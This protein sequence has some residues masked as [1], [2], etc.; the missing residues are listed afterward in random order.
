MQSV[1]YPR[2]P[3]SF[4]RATMS[5]NPKIRRVIY[6][7]T[8]IAWLVF[9]NSSPA[10]ES[11][12]LSR[13]L[14]QG[15]APGALIIKLDESS[16]GKAAPGPGRLQRL[17]RT[18][19][20]TAIHELF[21]GKTLISKAGKIVPERSLQGI[22]VLRLDPNADVEQAA[23]AY[24]AE[25]SV[26][27]AQPNYL[28]RTT[29]TPSVVRGTIS[30]SPPS[31][32][33]TTLGT[34][35][36]PRYKDQWALQKL[37]WDR[38]RE[39]AR[40]F[41]EVLVAIV[42]SGIDYNHEDLAERIWINR[43]ELD[44][45]EGVD[46]DQNGYV[47]DVRGWDFT[48]APTLP[49]IGDYI[50]RDNDPMD[51]SGHG[52][53]VAGIVGAAS[54]N[55]I[56]I[57]G[58]APNAR[59]MCLRAGLR[60][61]MGG[62]LEDDDAASAIVY[63]ADNGA[64]VIN[65]S[66]GDPRSSPLI[67]DVIR[68]AAHK[69]CVLV[70]AAGNEGNEALYYPAGLDETIAVSA[71]ESG[72]NIASY[73]NYGW[74]LD[75]V[76]PGS[77]ILSTN[78][79]SEY[80]VLSG[81]SMAAPHVSALAALILGENPDYSADEVRNLILHTAEDLGPPG[82]DP[83]FG[84][85]RINLQQAL[86]ANLGPT[87]QILHPQSGDGGDSALTVVGTAAGGDIARWELSYGPGVHPEAWTLLADSTAP[88]W[89]DTLTLWKPSDLP[90]SLYVL[91]LQAFGYDGVPTE[92]R[93]VVTIDHTPPH[94]Q[95][96]RIAERIDG[97]RWAS[98][99]E[100]ATDDVTTGTI[101]FRPSGSDQA[102]RSLE[103]TAEG[104]RGRGAEGLSSAPL[105]PCSL[106]VPF[107]SRHS[108]EISQVLSP[109]TYDF[110]IAA[111]N[112]AGL[113][114]QGPDSTCTIRGDVIPEQSYRKVAELPDGY[115]APQLSDFDGDGRKEIILMPY[116]DG[117]YQ[118]VQLFERASDNTFE[119]VF[120]LPEALLPWNGSDADRDGKWELMGVR[121][122]HLYLF[123]SPDTHSFPS[124]PIWDADDVWGGEATDLDGDGRTEIIARS[125]RVKALVVF[126]NDG[127]NSFPKV[128]PLLLNPTEG[129]ND[130]GTRFAIG[131][132]DR[133]GH[134]EIIFGDSD[135][136]LFA[137]EAKANN[138]YRSTII[139]H[140]NHEREDNEP[141]LS[142]AEGV[143]ARYVAGGSDLDGDGKLEFIVGK[144]VGDPLNPR[145]QRWILSIYQAKG[146]DAYEI[147]WQTEIL[148][149]TS[150]GNGIAVGDADGDGVDEFVVCARPDI[151]LF[152]S[153]G[154]NAYRPLWHAE[155]GLT[156]VPLIGDA[157]SDGLP[158]IAFNQGERVVIYEMVPPSPALPAP[159]G[160]TAVP[161]DAST[162]QLTWNRDVPD[163]RTYRLYR[164][165][166]PDT[167]ETI[168]QGALSPPYID[169]PLQTDVTY[170]YALSVVD[171]DLVPPEGARSPVVQATPNPPP[172]LLEARP[173]LSEAE[174]SVSLRHV[175]LLFS[176][177]LG[178]SAQVTAHYTITPVLSLP[179]S[180]AKGEAEGA[181]TSGTRENPSANAS[182]ISFPLHPSSA[183][184][185]Y[186]GQRVVLGFEQAL[187]PDTYTIWVEGVRDTTGVFLSSKANRATFSV[188]TAAM[189][190]R[191]ISV[192]ALSS[193][194]IRLVFSE[195]IRHEGLEWSNFSIL[196][197]V[198]IRAIVH[199]PESREVR[200]LLTESD[201][202]KARGQ[203][204]EIRVASL[205]DLNGA[206]VADVAYLKW[207]RDDLSHLIVFP[208]PCDLSES[209]LTFA[210]L[211]PEA[212]I[213]IYTLDGILV[214][215][216]I[217]QDGDDRTEWDGRNEQGE[218]IGSGIYLYSVEGRKQRR[219]GKFAV[220]R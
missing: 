154:E 179:L 133:D 155:T 187:P 181:D 41:D 190:T 85:G 180:E 147:E 138:I 15:Y 152:K 45:I 158:E 117:P 177:P 178:P 217:E 25:P 123:E 22:Y 68:Y 12:E 5:A 104:Q 165:T 195:G 82:W 43:A 70:A 193:T 199:T 142:E 174:G 162:V 6:L 42:D 210:N 200:L 52:T 37:G 67:R 105:L 1:V 36:D 130:I 129:D 135:G 9:P 49:G 171:S 220:I 141:V 176:E 113:T 78:L 23:S 159:T 208:N 118:P 71:V 106:A 65:M 157:D 107:S 17:H 145:S 173:V 8:L 44:G 19:G 13:I 164:G 69:G 170:F 140:E 151:Y 109:G 146:D 110:R 31:S 150:K 86:S 16:R 81:T 75:V 26:L 94:I 128:K 35:N 91:R 84:T 209:P 111:R 166:D 56:G 46:D 28:N 189:E 29:S 216:L 196:P 122:G 54:D 96:L 169:R 38:I 192:E 188:E 219:M 80:G 186:G 32:G 137:Y 114:V 204:Y 185:G 27:Y 161:I 218:R 83:K 100:W 48:D 62:F 134:T 33:S 18:F 205:T 108:V 59:L 203:R 207:A 148:G 101:R 198:T 4:E 124:K 120:T 76:A 168:A 119:P 131:D 53:H 34:P 127:D 103:T 74:N 51:E 73:A 202:L 212:T 175:A 132:F 99:L 214:K 50:V 61:S 149:V 184:V 121:A 30:N 194:E 172:R 98:F 90:D 3:L 21:P 55:G 57:A 97:V 72:D 183:I 7:M 40:T 64:R 167:L 77:N 139:H 211:T 126:E 79:N 160:L 191:I 201:P 213:E 60:L 24:Q 89:Q 87:V 95:Y 182:E 153:T 144:T 197:K 215:T 47:D 66:W 11:D 115:I 156:Y 20:V 125:D 92:D 206:P 102:Y 2:H 163:T 39:R 116:G 58:I 10:I 112:K 63:A 14:R 143:D 136:D 88:V 93:V